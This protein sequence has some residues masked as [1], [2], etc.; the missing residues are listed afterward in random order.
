[1][2]PGSSPGVEARSPSDP[3]LIFAVVVVPLVIAGFVV[4]RRQT[5]AGEHLAGEDAEAEARTEQEFAEA[6]PDEAGW[7]EEVK[8]RYR[9]HGFL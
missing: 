1:M 6:E 3:W 9:E 8:K 4:T 2:G 7:R 5:P